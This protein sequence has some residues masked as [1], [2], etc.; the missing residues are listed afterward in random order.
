MY[1]SWVLM[2]LLRDIIAFIL[3]IFPRAHQSSLRK[4]YDFNQILMVT[5]ISCWVLFTWT[6]RARRTI[7]C[8]ARVWR[9]SLRLSP[10]Q[11]LPLVTQLLDSCPLH[12]RWVRLA[13]HITKPILTSRALTM[14]PGITGLRAGQSMERCIGR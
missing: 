4:K 10:R 14:I 5:S 7:R 9:C 11:R 8:I 6:I 13:I 3:R 12:Y 2:E 1:L